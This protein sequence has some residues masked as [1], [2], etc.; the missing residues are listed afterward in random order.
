MGSGRETKDGGEGELRRNE[1]GSWNREEI[2]GE[3]DE[4]R[5]KM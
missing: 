5:A 4:R 1:Y 2:R 3:I